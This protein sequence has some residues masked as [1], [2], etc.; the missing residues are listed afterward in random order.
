M[1]II[2][3]D[4]GNIYYDPWWLHMLTLT[5]PER[6]RKKPTKPGRRARY[7]KQRKYTPHKYTTPPPPHFVEGCPYSEQGNHQLQK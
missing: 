4:K 1:Y 5:F 7:K 6:E 2:I 3:K